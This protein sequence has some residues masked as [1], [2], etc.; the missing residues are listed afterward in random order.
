MTGSVVAC[1]LTRIL[2]L[3]YAMV[4]YTIPLDPYSFIIDITYNISKVISN[5]SVYISHQDDGIIDM[6]PVRDILRSW[7]SYLVR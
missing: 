1:S 4:S 5:T 2:T 7:N 6:L 3:S